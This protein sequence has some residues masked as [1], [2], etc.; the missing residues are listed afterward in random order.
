MN[1]RTLWEI[2]GATTQKTAIF[3][4]AAVRTWNLTITVYSENN[5][6]LINTLCGQNAKL[7]IVKRGGTCSYHWEVV[8]RRTIFIFI[9]GQGQCT[10]MAR[11]CCS[12]VSRANGLQLQH[13][14]ARMW[15]SHRLLLESI[16]TVGGKEWLSKSQSALSVRRERG[17]ENIR[18]VLK[19]AV[20]RVT[21]GVCASFT[22]VFRL[23]TETTFL[24]R[25]C[26]RTSISVPLLNIS[27]QF[28]CITL[29]FSSST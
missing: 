8:S 27:F 3:I 18:N 16:A 21:D 10:A 29:P 15:Q 7:L 11:A 19:I 17:E 26:Q 24:E 5:T 14:P 1:L 6:K 12:S 20:T 9:R 28:L 23:N 4:L 25:T 2:D 13:N 22:H